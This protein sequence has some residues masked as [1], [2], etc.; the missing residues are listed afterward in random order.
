MGTYYTVQYVGDA[1]GELALQREIETLLQRFEQQLSNWKNDSWINQFNR[2]GADQLLPVPEYAFAVLKLT[3]EL[4]EKSDGALDPTVAPLVELWGFG[5]NR[6]EDIPHDFAIQQT[7]I[8]VGFRQISLDQS[9]R[10]IVK[11]SGKIQLN[12]SA[13]AKGYAVDLLADLLQRSGHENFLINIGG[14]ISARGESDK[15]RVWRVAISAPGARAQVDGIADSLALENRAMATSGHTQRVFKT[16]GTLYSHI[17]DPRSGYP[18]AA[19]FASATVLSDSCA[20]ADG[21][22]T[23]ALVLS[24]TEMNTLL[25][26][27]PGTE[28]R[29]TPWSLPPPSEPEFS[30]LNSTAPTIDQ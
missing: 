19:T 2:L 28:L 13:V 21:L 5:V 8:H 16:A 3:L 30:R 7:L 20:L 15:G 24:E 12:C 27:Y 22:A 25:T 4:A 26:H 9:H 11:Q 1:A 6:A 14:E 18:V 17:I 23:L 10:T 29:I